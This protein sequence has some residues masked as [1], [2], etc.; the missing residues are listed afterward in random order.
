MSEM[1]IY[2]QL[3]INK[4]RTLRIPRALLHRI[5]RKLSVH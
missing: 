3:A 2:Q 5:V 4:R 1:A